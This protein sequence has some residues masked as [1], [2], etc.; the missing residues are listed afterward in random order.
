[1]GTQPLVQ[2]S[3]GTTIHL[4]LEKGFCCTGYQFS[5][6]SHTFLDKIFGACLPY[7]SD[8]AAF[9]VLITD[10]ESSKSRPTKNHTWK[11][12]YFIVNFLITNQNNWSFWLTVSKDSA[13]MRTKCITSLETRKT[14]IFCYLG[15]QK[16]QAKTIV[17]FKE[18]QGTWRSRGTKFFTLV[19]LNNCNNSPANCH[20]QF[21]I[22]KGWWHRRI[23]FWSMASMRRC[24]GKA[25]N[26]GKRT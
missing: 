18:K 14:A 22:P 6:D 15:S 1:M 12:N 19:R 2:F 8:F 24:G 5:K 16:R 20:L 21:S 4:R 26:N 10:K 13:T 11:I 25:W 23:C 17:T 3:V 7:S 9:F